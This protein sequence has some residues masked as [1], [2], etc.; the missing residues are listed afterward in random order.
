[1]RCIYFHIRLALVIALLTQQAYTL[2]YIVNQTSDTVDASIPG[3][4][5]WAIQ[6]ANTNQDTSNIIK[7]DL[8]DDTPIR[9][10]ATLPTITKKLIINGFNQ[11]PTKNK[12]NRTTI[13][14]KNQAIDGL[15]FSGEKTAGSKVTG[16]VLHGF[17]ASNKSAIS[18]NQTKKIKIAGNVI[19]TD[20]PGTKSEKNYN[21]ISLKESSNITIGGFKETSKNLIS[22]NEYGI[23]ISPRCSNCAIINNFIGTNAQGTASL[24]NVT[25]IQILEGNNNIINNNTISGQT[26]NGIEAINSKNLII[27]GNRIGTNA[28]GTQALRN[29]Q[30]GI[31]LKK[32]DSPQIGGNDVIMR[33]IISGN[34]SHNIELRS[35]RNAIVAG[36]FIGTDIHGNDTLGNSCGIF[37]AH[38]SASTI[39]DYNATSLD[40]GGNLV[41]GNEHAGMIIKNSHNNIITKNYIGL[42]ATGSKIIPNGKGIQLTGGS[43]NIIGPVNFITGNTEQALHLKTSRCLIKGNIIGLNA[44]G[45]YATPNAYNKSTGIYLEECTQTIIGGKKTNSLNK[46]IISG[47]RLGQGIFLSKSHNCKIQGNYIGTSA[48]GTQ[49]AG[50]QKGIKLE[51]SRFNQIGG[52]PEE[53]NLISGNWENGIVLSESDSCAIQ[54]NFIGTDIM[55]VYEIPN[56]LDGIK[57]QHLTSFLIGGNTN[58]GNI[59]AGN[60]SSGINVFDV[61]AQEA[62]IISGNYIG[63]G[64]DGINK[65]PNKAHG[66]ILSDSTSGISINARNVISGNQQ[67]GIYLGLAKN[68]RINNNYIGLDCSGTTTIKNGIN[69]FIADGNNRESQQ[70]HNNQVTNNLMD[71]M[72]VIGLITNTL[73]AQER[74]NFIQPIE[75]NADSII[76]LSMPETQDNNASALPQSDTQPIETNNCIA[77]ET[78][79]AD[80]MN[81][82]NIIDQPTE[83]LAVSN[84]TA[85]EN[86]SN[87]VNQETQSAPLDQAKQKPLSEDINLELHF[88]DLYNALLEPLDLLRTDK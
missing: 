63:L 31:F 33:N 58:Q 74:E 71:E 21:G 22:G 81:L 19:G 38:S 23:K 77:T 73:A 68:T 41:S 48:D 14:T 37:L 88:Y 12:N 8:Q 3:E 64:A 70:D 50:N 47:N 82:S 27:T 16:L 29:N 39:G 55:G 59:I 20:A 51:H 83:D 34:G 17:N 4:L 46:N 42:D 80:S 35:C 49:A 65:L 54:N 66:I 30:R 10:N 60:N 18:L 79:T 76:T 36:N 1:M 53:G 25:G 56:G 67:A 87:E 11:N 62:G 7:F 61:H 75:M 72:I 86:I 2:T 52:T 44:Q 28:T 57:L 9:L 15:V 26:Q 40:D 85:P 78:L 32:C 24:G 5:R 84:D 69:I 6:Q 45:N 43:N 13:T